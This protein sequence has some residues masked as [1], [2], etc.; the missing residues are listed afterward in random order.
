MPRF[1]T[2]GSC[3]QKGSIFSEIL[4]RGELFDK[5]LLLKV[6]PFVFHNPLSFDPRFVVFPVKRRSN[7][8]T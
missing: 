7:I 2:S 4:Y 3:S 8:V 1:T 5:S 6:I